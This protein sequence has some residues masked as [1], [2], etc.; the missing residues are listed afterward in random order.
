MNGWHVTT[1]IRRASD[2]GRHHISHQITLANPGARAIPGCP[3]RRFGNSRRPAHDLDFSL[4]LYQ[5]LPVDKKVGI[6]EFGVG[7]T[8]LKRRQCARRK[9]IGVAFIPYAGTAKSPVHHPGGDMR[10]W[11]RVRSLD[12]RF[13]IGNELRFAQIGGEFRRAGI[14][15]PAHPEGPVMKVNQHHLGGVE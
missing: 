5:P 15:Q 8:R 4:A 12:Q 11:M 13:R 6:N 2:L 7:E 9:K 1:L 3:H 10:H 14:H